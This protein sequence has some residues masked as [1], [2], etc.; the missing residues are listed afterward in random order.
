MMIAALLL[1]ALGVVAYG[2]RGTGGESSAGKAASDTGESVG[3][4]AEDAMGTAKSAGSTMKE[5]ARNAA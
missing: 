1:S 4:A 5:A 2:R 3:D